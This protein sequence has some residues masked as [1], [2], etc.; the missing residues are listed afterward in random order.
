M[1]SVKI[2]DCT[3][4]DGGY[5]T[6]WDFDEQLVKDYYQ[7][8]ENLPVDYVEIGY[9]SIPMDSYLGKFFYCPEYVMQEAKK[10]MPSKKL[11]IILNE[12]DVELSD[13]DYLIEPCKG[14]I[15]LI[16][17]AVNPSNFE[18]AVK[19]AAYLKKY[20]FQV[21]FNVMYMSS[22]NENK[23]F[24]QSLPLVNGVVDYFYMVDSFGGVLPTQVVET[25]N[26]L[27]SSLKI[28]FG[29][30]GH[31]NLELGLINSITAMEEGCELIDS[32]ITGMG[33]GAGNLKTELILTYLSSRGNLEK[34][35]FSELSKVVDSFEELQK[36][37]QWGTNL[38]YMISGANSLP[39]KDVMNWISKRRYSVTG[40]VNALQNRK[41]KISD[42]LNVPDFKPTSTY[43]K[44]LIIGGGKTSL[45][46]LEAVQRAL[47][48][49]K[50]RNDTCIIHAST[51]YA[52]EYNNLNVSQY[53]CLVG[54]EGHRLKSAF[55]SLDFFE[56]KCI[57]PPYPREMGTYIPEAIKSHTVQLKSVSISDLYQDSPLTVALQTALELRSSEVVFI[58][59]DGYDIDIN[60]TQVQLSQENQYV[61]NNAI[62]KFEDTQFWTPTKYNN[63]PKRS[64]YSLLG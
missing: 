6:N 17:I 29:F 33:R 16:R 44:A 31:N 1:S 59:F 24:L 12:K 18:R 50:Y 41:E 9:R 34:F 36:Y 55:D 38:P 58:G 15:D 54:N 7:A 63:I 20:E 11:A 53:Y 8:M 61:L 64:V 47:E 32:T 37:H 51:R 46:H 40:I 21:A 43:K 4:R 57:L 28:T 42:N 62:E 26:M 25:T 52:K 22:W 27:K 39:Q 13:V 45:S 48:N 60:P 49:P 2:L 56:H 30:H 14:Y 23:A 10:A 5:Y 35:S 3:L 19:L